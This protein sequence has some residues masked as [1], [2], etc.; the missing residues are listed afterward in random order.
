[1]E[2]QVK[3][4]NQPSLQA[5][6]D[7]LKQTP[8]YKTP[9]KLVAHVN[10]SKLKDYSVDSPVV[11]NRWLKLPAIEEKGSKEVPADVLGDQVDGTDV[12]EATPEPPSSPLQ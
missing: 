6:L 2:H 3:T 5:S 10:R 7:S 12:N 11:T 9:A 1:M 8:F 4:D